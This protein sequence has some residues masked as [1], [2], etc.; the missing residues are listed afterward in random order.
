MKSSSDVRSTNHVPAMEDH[1]LRREIIVMAT[2][3]SLVNR[4]GPMFAIRA[5][6]DTSADIGQIARAYREMG[7]GPVAASLLW[8]ECFAG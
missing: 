1:P 8:D 3:N 2:T 7:S 6:E 4:M 5:M